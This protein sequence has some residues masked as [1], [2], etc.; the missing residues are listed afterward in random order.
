MLS[1]K[2]WKVAAS[3][4]LVAVL[5]VTMVFT[6]MPEAGGYYAYAETGSLETMTPEV[7]VSGTAVIG[8]SA[9]TAD[10]VSLERSYTRD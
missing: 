7:V 1:G 8:G 5:A 10:N 4:L 6:M 2:R 9:Y 3:R